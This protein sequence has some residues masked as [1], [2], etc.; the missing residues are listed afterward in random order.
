MP[1]SIKRTVIQRINITRQGPEQTRWK[2]SPSAV[3]CNMHYENFVGPSK[4]RI[5]VYFKKSNA[6]PASKKARTEGRKYAGYN[7]LISE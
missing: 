4:T 3:I 7:Y 6:P 5:P 1:V 2:A